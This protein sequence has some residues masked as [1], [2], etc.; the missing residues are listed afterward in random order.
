M[1]CA[2]PSSGKDNSIMPAD[3]KQ[4]LHTQHQQRRIL[5]QV[6]AMVNLG[7]YAATMEYAK[8]APA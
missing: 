1:E 3:S 6:G 4:Y 7:R 5:L 8:T 2:G